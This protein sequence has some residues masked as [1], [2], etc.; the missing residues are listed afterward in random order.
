MLVK[1]ASEFSLYGLVEWRN[2]YNIFTQRRPILADWCKRI[3]KTIIEHQLNSEVFAGFQQLRY[4][5][6]IL[7]RYQQMAQISNQVYVFGESGPNDPQLNGLNPVVLN[8]NDSL[9][10]EWFLVVNHKHYCRALVALEI[11]PFGTPHRDRVFRGMMTSEVH[12]VS[13]LHAA[14]RE[15][16]LQ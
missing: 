14:I 2:V 4:L 5:T 15:A 6:P 1:I 7:S 8:H 12:Q 3:E 13:R 9:V 11:T 10:R 16:T